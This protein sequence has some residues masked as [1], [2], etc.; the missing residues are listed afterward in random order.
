ME[1]MYRTSKKDEDLER[2]A[3]MYELAEVASKYD[4]FD[5]EEGLLRFL[6]EV[7]LASDQD[8]KDDSVPMVKLMTIHA[9]KGLEFETV[10]VSG[11]EESMFTPRLA[12]EKKVSEEKAEEER[13]LFY[14]AMT[15]ARKRL[16]LTWAN[17]RMVYGSTEVNLICSFVLDIPDVH[18]N[19]EN[20]GFSFTNQRFQGSENGDDEE[21]VYLDW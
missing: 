6:E 9:A 20:V 10:F 21:I 7:S 5:S 4:V 12:L 16:F 17:M 15:R 13:R 18:L 1:E 19:E 2:I 3:N 8:S 14:V 11:C